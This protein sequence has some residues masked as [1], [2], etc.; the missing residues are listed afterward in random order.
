[1]FY[2]YLSG[3][4]VSYV[5]YVPD[6]VLIIVGI[7]CNFINLCIDMKNNLSYNDKI[8]YPVV[9][10]VIVFIAWGFYCYIK[11]LPNPKFKTSII[12]ALCI[13]FIFTWSMLGVRINCKHKKK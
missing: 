7:G 2:T 5:D 4:T 13:L 10:G 1:M 3:Y 6:L 8:I 11:K 12:F 9:S